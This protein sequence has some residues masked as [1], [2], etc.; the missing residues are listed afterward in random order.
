MVK[1]RDQLEEIQ[2]TM[3]DPSVVIP[4]R[5]YEKEIQIQLEK[6]SLIEE[7]IM[8]QNSRVQWLKLGDANIAYFFAPL[9]NRVAQNT[10]NSLMRTDGSKAQTQDELEHEVIS[11]ARQV[12]IY[13]VS[14]SLL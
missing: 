12:R 10:I 7:S 14:I 6:R 11:L 13:L 5:Q 1:L 9:K 3:K 2:E 8:P 4:T